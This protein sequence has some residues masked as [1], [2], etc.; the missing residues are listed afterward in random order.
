M[1][2][3]SR[4]FRQKRRQSSP[5]VLLKWEETDLP[6]IAAH[7]V[8]HAIFHAYRFSSPHNTPDAAVDITLAYNRLIKT[9]PVPAIAAA[10]NTKGAPNPKIAGTQDPNAEVRHPS[11][12]WPAEPTEWAQ[13]SR[14]TER[15]Q[16]GA[17]EFFASAREALYIS[18]GS[19][20][21]AVKRYAKMDGTISDIWGD[22]INL[23]ANLKK[24]APSTKNKNPSTAEKAAVT[25]AQKDL[26]GMSKPIA[27]IY[28]LY[29]TRAEL[30]NFTFDPDDFVKNNARA[31]EVKK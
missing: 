8:G 2:G 15:A 27:L 28:L 5:T 23:L 24:Q 12:I 30:L 21:S 29:R 18:R 4:F 25:Q 14:H 9:K 31:E 7:E 6:A 20:E 13:T 22:F 3:S 17:D 11:G 16:D 1:L 26:A 10:A 19:L